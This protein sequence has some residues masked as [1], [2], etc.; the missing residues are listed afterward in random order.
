M[1]FLIAAALTIF[2]PIQAVPQA[3]NAATPPRQLPPPAVLINFDYPDEAFRA[4]QQGTVKVVL[5][6]GIDGKIV[7]CRVTQPRSPSL[8]AATCK[9]M[10][11]F[12]FEPALDAEGH[13]VEGD[14]PTSLNWKLPK[15]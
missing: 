1:S 12:S 2:A 14:Y 15:R 4:R 3:T 8:D 7:G 11:Q 10:A 13:A 6:I 5:R 9:F